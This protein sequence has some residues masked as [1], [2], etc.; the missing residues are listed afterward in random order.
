MD[1]DLYN[2]LDDSHLGE[3]EIPCERCAHMRPY[4]STRFFKMTCPGF[5]EGIPLAIQRGEVDHTEAVEGDH[6]YRF[7]P[8]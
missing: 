3:R 1:E 8:V 6:G 4:T 5:P 7:K 2:T